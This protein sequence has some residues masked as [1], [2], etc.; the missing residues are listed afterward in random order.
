[1][2]RYR[3]L[4][5]SGLVVSPL[6]L[7]TM[8]FATER[9]G[10]PAGEAAA[11]FDAYVEAGGNFVDTA[12]VYAGGR[13]E[14]MV[15]QLIA[16][17][18]LRDQLVLATKFGFHAGRGHGGGP[19]P[20]AGGNGRKQIHRALE[21]SLRRLQTDRVDLY[22][23]HV[24]DT[25]TPAEELLVTLTD[26][27]R[28]GKILYYGLSDMP[29][30]YAAKVAALA[31]AHGVPGPAAIQ[32]EY[33]LVE[34]TVEREH[35]PAAR[36]AGLGVC[37]WSPLAGGFLSGKYRPSA[38]GGAGAMGDGRLSGSNPFQNTKFTERN[39]AVLEVL[40]GVAEEAGTTPAQAALAWLTGRPGVTSTIVGATGAEQLR[41]NIAALDVVLPPALT[42]ALDRASA[43]EPA[44][45]YPIFTPEGRRAIF[46]A[47]VAGW[48]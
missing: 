13:G 38:E 20:N 47:E 16:E 23:M 35:L 29:A 5:R 7:G 46:G 37:P 44:F 43:P 39:W 8:T 22:W 26:L 6:A 11:V 17:R 9:W 33:S 40:R 34:R 10:S 12:D 2:T 36:D 18:G 48:A 41:G 31:S 32:I 21:G 30:W 24:W 15:G 27:I 4:G 14:E 25:V 1:M 42:A 45:P 19:D 3:T 28:S